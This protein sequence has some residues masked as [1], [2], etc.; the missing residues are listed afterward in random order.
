MKSDVI[1]YK[2]F[3]QL[4]SEI[5]ASKKHLIIGIDIGKDNHHAFFGTAR[6][7]TL[8]K[9]LIFNN[10]ID[11]FKKLIDQVKEL[12]IQYSLTKTV[13]GMEP[14]GNYHKPLAAWLINNEHFPVLV[15]GKAVKDNRELLD[16]RWDKNDD[17]DSANIADLI[18]QGK[19]L[20][21]ENPEE[22]IIELRNLLS[23]RKRLKKEEH[24]LKMR[25]RNGLLV[26][27]FPEMD[28]YWGKSIKENLAIVKWCIDPKKIS[29][30]DFMDFVKRVT[31][32]DRGKR[33]LDR[34]RKIYDAAA[35]SI[36][37]P[38]DI[39][40]EFE[41]KMLADR[42][43]R[44]RERIKATMQKIETV[45]RKHKS[46]TILQ[47]IPGFGPFIAA[48]VIAVIGNP[49]RFNSYKQVIRLAGYDLNA[50]RSGKT[51]SSAVAVISKKGDS[52][53][54]YGLYQASMVGTYHNHQFRR[55]FNRVLKGRER[56]RGIKTKMR[57]KI[58][59]KMLVIAWTLMKK[60]EPFNADFLV[61]D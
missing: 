26:R 45:A 50:S 32:T 31:T 21:Y 29:K 11:G 16:G 60:E 40:V 34:L 47:T 20:F 51:S 58:A 2:K 61:T 38:V 23:L 30:M 18:S 52:E 6:G 35:D 43:K 25:I 37:M 57:V 13:F 56:E 48:L 15:S 5:R 10:N 44:I 8:L 22:S 17:K 39:S 28:R 7:K 1:R 46:Y 19:C 36:G 59:T 3:C 9:R 14:T 33:Q 12:Q 54:R 24:R 27:Y 55:L 49:F 4:K 42:L 53:L 41:A